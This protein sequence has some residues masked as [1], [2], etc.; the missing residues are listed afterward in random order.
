M[1]IAYFGYY[2]EEGLRQ[3]GHEVCP[4]PLTK[5]ANLET[6][7][8]NH[9]PGADFV[10]L[11]LFGGNFPFVDMVC[12]KYRL[13]LY[14]IDSPLNEFWLEHI[15]KLA[16]DVFLD[17]RSSLEVLAGAGI[18]SAWLP[19][20]V[21][22]RDFRGRKAPQHDISFVGTINAQRVKR[23][24]ILRCIEER[25]SLN[26][27]NNVS[28]ARMQDIFSESKISI[29]ENL[30]Y[31]LT[32][33]VLQGMAAGTV[34]FTE[35]NY[36]DVHGIF[37]DGK[38][39]VCY[40]PD[41]LL[42]RLTDV[43]ENYPDYIQVASAG[44]ELCR[45]RHTSKVRAVE[46]LE[47]I[48]Q[49]NASNQRRS[50]AERRYHFACAEYL[51]SVR[52]G[53]Y[54]GG[55]RKVFQEILDSGEPDA[56]VG[57]AALML[58]DIYAR[59]EYPQ[60]ACQL[61]DISVEK[62]GSMEGAIKSAIVCCGEKNYLAAMRNLKRAIRMAAPPA[63]KKPAGASGESSTEPSVATLDRPPMVL[64]IELADAMVLLLDDPQNQSKE[65]L[66]LFLAARLFFEMG[67]INTLG[68]L[69]SQK[70]AVPGAALPLAFKAWES[71]NSAEILDFMLA[72]ARKAGVEIELLPTLVSAIYGL[73]AER[74]HIVCAAELAY[75]NYDKHLSETLVANMRKFGKSSLL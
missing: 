69:G 25:F 36:T 42:P 20:C 30:F 65:S 12:C 35:A 74:R 45:L 41:T 3:L 39:L 73:T 71:E 66:L 62:D 54:I 51:F 70:D 14:C 2:L 16:D 48:R 24:N 22:E 43:L 19:L 38:E 27:Q 37:E 50:N 26:V 11:E 47:H 60:E 33:R 9:C 52:F 59:L 34:L 61:Y 23:A 31:G 7:I 57:K 5:G 64:P 75:K 8:S 46:L 29:N 15:T 68:F 10:L 55:A 67:K 44:Q 63:T 6:L 21:Y 1:Q 13:V 49:E 53:G 32:L 56:F 4:L 18:R 72:C 40:E 28:H 58:G 17:Q